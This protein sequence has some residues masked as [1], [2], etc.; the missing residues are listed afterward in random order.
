LR[1]ISASPGFGPFSTLR[2]ACRL[3]GQ[4]LTGGMRHH[5]Q[6]PSPTSLA[7][8]A[9]PNTLTPSPPFT[10]CIL[11]YFSNHHF[12]LLILLRNTSVIL[13]RYLAHPQ[14]AICE[15][16]RK[17][18]DEKLA[19]IL[20]SADFQ[21][22]RATLWKEISAEAI[23]HGFVGRG[24]ILPD[25]TINPNSERWCQL[26]SRLVCQV[27]KGLHDAWW[28]VSLTNAVSRVT[29]G[30]NTLPLSLPSISICPRPLLT[31]DTQCAEASRR[32]LSIF[33]YES[34]SDAG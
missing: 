2:S 21:P 29:T 33:P 25:Q 6:L 24:D 16:A 13:E 23:A 30:R 11:S 18:M 17:P 14:T 3:P 15:E 22:W 26:Y 32:G 12:S 34:E 5:L 19:K 27:R 20:A 9:T 8:Q 28:N 1:L 7:A 4:S 31:P 10:S